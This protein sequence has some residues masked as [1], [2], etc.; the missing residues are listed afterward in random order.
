MKPYVHCTHIL[1][2]IFKVKCT[3][4]KKKIVIEFSF[5]W[6]PRLRKGG[7]VECVRRRDF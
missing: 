6:I 5:A 4:L 3:L 2:G 1:L 7:K